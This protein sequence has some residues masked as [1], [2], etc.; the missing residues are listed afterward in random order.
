MATLFD[1]LTENNRFAPSLPLR[2]RQQINVKERATVYVLRFTPSMDSCSFLID[3]YIIN[4][5]KTEKCDYVV[6]AKSENGSWAEV[7]V[8]LKGADIRHAIIQLKATLNHPYFKSTDY[9]IRKARVVT[10]NRIPAN[11]GNSIVERAKVDFRKMGC[12]F[13]PIKSS[14]PDLLKGADFN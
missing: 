13:R 2:L 7:F 5:M 9:S 3:G 14:Q 1:I 8:E 6:L 4:D 10:S 11:T 12:D